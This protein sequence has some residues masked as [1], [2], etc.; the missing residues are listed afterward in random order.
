MK[1]KKI[2]LLICLLI[3]ACSLTTISSCKKNNS[4]PDFVMPEG[5]YDNSEVTI[6]FYH[7]MGQ[8]LQDVLNIYIDE[9]NE[10]YPNIT[11]E[12]LSIGSYD[13]VRDQVKT[14]LSIGEQANI[15]YCYPDH[16]ALYNKAKSVVTLDEL[17]DDTENGL[18]M[19]ATQKADFVDA[20]Y[21]EGKQFGDG[22][23][24]CLPFSKSTEVLYYDKTFFAKNNLTVPTTWAEMEEVCKAIKTIDSKSIPLGYDSDSN[25]FITSCEQLG[26]GYTS[27]NAPYFTF[28]NETNRA[29]VEK[30]KGWYDKGYVTTKSLYGSYTSGLFTS[31]SG[32]RCYMCIGSSA[33][34]T[35]QVP[36]KVNGAYPFEVG[37]TSIPQYD[38]TNHPAVIS[39]GPSVCIFKS[40]N[41]Q[42]VV[43]S[44]L[45]VRYLLTS[46][47]FQAEFSINSGYVPVLESVF[48]NTEYK[49]FLA[50]ADGGDNIAAQSAKVCVAQKSY[51]YA[52]PAFVGSAS[53]RDEVGSL[54]AA[55][56]S[57]AKTTDKAFKDAIAACEYQVG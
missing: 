38:A 31:N 10:V 48:D 9:F 30:Y 50:K 33:G 19:T 4:L 56:L 47:D 7:T 49:K 41:M 1:M 51:Y 24:Y 16:V 8:N 45:F 14:E 54:L 57:E 23:M 18:G 36:E 11:I 52:S 37:I 35:Y 53:A 3:V 25:W 28:D 34:A 39:Q 43:A 32:V 12:S 15:V 21:D 55:V 5:G 6:R 40:K 20:Y 22:K 2:R 46:V 13:D 29:F 26:S 42:Q 17:M 44:W 27:A